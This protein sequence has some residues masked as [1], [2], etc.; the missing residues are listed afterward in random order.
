MIWGGELSVEEFHKIFQDDI[1]KS[2][3]LEKKHAQ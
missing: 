3:E 2:I 1:D